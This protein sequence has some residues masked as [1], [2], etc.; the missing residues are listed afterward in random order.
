MKNTRLILSVCLLLAGLSA[1]AAA[2]KPIKILAIG[3]SF[4]ND[5]VNQNLWDLAAADGQTFIIGNLYIGGCPL[6]KH[7][8]NAE[9]DLPAYVY[10]KISADGTLVS[11]K[12]YK[13]STALADEK[14]DVVVFQQKSGLSGIV[15]SYEPYLGNLYEYVKYRV[16]KKCRFMFHQTWAYRSNSTNPDFV[17]Y[18]RSS[19]KMYKAIMEASSEICKKYSFEVIP[20]GTTVQNLRGSEIRENVTRDGYHLN[21]PI[22]RYALACAW[23]EA[24]SGRTCVGN[25]YAP[26]VTEPWM[27]EICQA[28]AHAAIEKPFEKTK[29]GP[30]ANPTLRDE[31]GVPA[32]TLPDPLVK[33]DGTKVKDANDW[34]MNRRP[35]ILDFYLNEVYGKSPKP[36]QDMHFKV[37]ESS[38]DAFGGLATRKQV[39]LYLTKTERYCLHLLIY[40]P[41]KV[42]GPAPVFMGINFNGNWGV[43]DDPAIIMPDKAQMRKYNIVE[44]Y[45][46]RGLNARRWPLEQIL[47]AGY[48]VVTFYRG[49]VDPDFYDGFQNG[50]APMIYKKGQKYPEPDQWGTISQWAWGLSRA[51][52]Y[53]TIDK[54]IDETRV[55]VIGHSRLGKTSLWAAAQDP[56]FAISISNCSGAGGADIFHR[57]FGE[58]IVD[59]N[60]HFPHWFCGNFRKYNGQELNL[61]F[62]QHFLAALIAPRPL[63]IASADGDLW[64]DPKGEF[65]CAKE[66]SKVYEFL[67]YPGV[68]ASEWPAAEV[69]AMD[70]TVAYHMRHGKHDIVSY[71]WANY[72]KFA[73]RYFKK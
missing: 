11:T 47:S 5:A 52:D 13:I 30:N 33:N 21:D 10:H 63:Y 12:G 8:R 14:W 26:A 72:I 15:D 37:V 36:S 7:W 48:G 34:M 6:D 23:Y 29:V 60:H 64:A 41:N 61:P 62:D 57:T 73:D 46:T 49:D 44:N 68:S 69:P 3:N 17:K 31:A 58:S 38:S 18:D 59:L 25:P 19:G 71:D 24:I 2:P 45:D 22:G 39:D 51:L 56:R 4:S 54:D 35:E 53:A 55:A 16:P 27:K 66:A 28:A 65:L 67:G 40:L 50:I 20:G 42:E 70:G 43:S 32:Y 1:S 9:G